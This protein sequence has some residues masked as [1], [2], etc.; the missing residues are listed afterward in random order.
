AIAGRTDEALDHLIGFF[1]NT[2]VLRGD[3]SGNPSFRELLTRTR[4]TALAAYDHQDLP[5][6]RLV[7]ALNP[8][9][10]LNSH[11]VFQVMLAY[12]NDS[13]IAPRIPGVETAIRPVRAS[14]AKFDLT[15]EFTEHDGDD[16]LTGV[17]EFS[18][19]VF[20]A[21]TAESIAGRLTRLLEAVTTAPDAPVASL[22]ILTPEERAL[23]L[24]SWNATSP[25]VPARTAVALFEAQVEQAPEALALLSTDGIR[26]TYA[27]LDAR[28][29]RLARRLIGEGVGPEDIV[30]VALPRSVA[31]VVSMLGVLKA[32]AAYLP[33]DVTYP[34]E[35]IAYM[36]EDASPVLTI[37]SVDAACDLP[38]GVP[39]L[40]IGEWTEAGGDGSAPRDADRTAPLSVRHPAYMIYTSGSTG[41]PKGV[42]V[43]HAGIASLIATQVERF[44]VG[45]RSRV[46]QFASPSF[47]AAFWE[48]GMALFTG[49]AL[50]VAPPDRLLPGEP[51]AALVAE[52]GVTQL[53]L[54]PSGLALMPDDGLPAGVSLAVG[55]EAT[56]PALVEQWSR[57]RRMVN[58]YGPTEATVCATMSDPLS[59]GCLP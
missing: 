51:L 9:R 24:D 18:T 58:A 47:D 41:R 22:D 1:V 48:L 11:P 38:D 53:M 36:L 34:A 45:P 21:R 40:V 13:G 29:N 10:T 17:L 14:I 6:N 16:G 15:F 32:G 55:G 37:T 12:Q 49:A 7:E 52:F 23:L 26:L 54:P 25:P 50:V 59:G 30:A 4:E 43:S 42:V 3:T 33:V 5:F 44:E 20:D 28:A 27:E 35:R 8:E 31:M 2:L 19:D 46:L 39:Q 57:G 56:N